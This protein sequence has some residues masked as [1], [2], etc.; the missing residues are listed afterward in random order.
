MYLEQINQWLH[1]RNREALYQMVQLYLQ[2]EFSKEYLPKKS[3]LVSGRILAA[4]TN[5]ELALD[6]KV[7]YAEQFS[8]I[9]DFLTAW[10]ELKFC[11]WEM[12]FLGGDK[13]LE[14]MLLAINEGQVT[15]IAL[16]YLISSSAVY[17]KQALL[18]IC[19]GLL[20]VGGDIMKALWLLARGCELFPEDT[21]VR[22]LFSQL[23]ETLGGS[24][25]E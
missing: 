18:T 2:E 23:S 24:R 1:Q 22:E 16:K 8:G 19:G 4:I 21:E 15:D 17:K 11:L 13:A 6:R 7:L 9:D 25:H 3:E 12:E 5:D 14:A 10:N 20:S